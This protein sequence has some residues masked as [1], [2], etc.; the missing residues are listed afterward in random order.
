[1]VHGEAGEMRLLKTIQDTGWTTYSRGSH[2][3]SDAA[4]YLSTNPEADERVTSIVDGVREGHVELQGITLIA[5]S[6]A[7]PYV[8]VEGTARLVAVY[9]QCVIQQNRD[10]GDHIEVVLGI[11]EEVWQWSPT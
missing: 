11:S 1:M 9:V 8:I 3:L 5:H 4:N 10:L 2:I 6:E 7:G